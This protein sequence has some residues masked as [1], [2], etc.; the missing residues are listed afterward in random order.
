MMYTHEDYH[1]L[2][3]IARNTPEGTVG[4]PN[5]DTK[6]VKSICMPCHCGCGVLV[7]VKDGRVVKIEDDPDFPEE[8]LIGG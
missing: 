1:P 2:C 7:Y 5:S 3:V 4:N 6:I 8:A